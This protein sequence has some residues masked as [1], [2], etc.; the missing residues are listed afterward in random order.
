MN[1][2]AFA[3]F[4]NQ[5]YSGLSN[6]LNTLDPYEFSLFGVIAAYLIAPSLNANQQN[7]I[8]NFL[9]EIGQIILTIAAQNI[10]VRQALSNNTESVGNFDSANTSPGNYSK[11]INYQNEIVRLNQEIEYLKRKLNL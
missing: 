6:W 10:T 4:T 9:E 8:G 2:E 1:N 3:N 7:S 11:N 5:D